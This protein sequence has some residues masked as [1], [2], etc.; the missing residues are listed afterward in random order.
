M[1]LHA[2]ATFGPVIL[3]DD[4]CI[5]SPLTI[6][7]RN[8]NA[9][10]CRTSDSTKHKHRGPIRRLAK[11]HDRRTA[12]NAK[13]NVSEEA[14]RR[15][16][17][18]TKAISNLDQNRATDRLNQ[19]RTHCEHDGRKSTRQKFCRSVSTHSGKTREKKTANH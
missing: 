19:A 6:A 18:Q 5:C 11:K 9:K 8:S 3:L 16:R 1:K 10:T 14:Q 2:P 17:L 13:H 4:F 7:D 12:Q 15:A